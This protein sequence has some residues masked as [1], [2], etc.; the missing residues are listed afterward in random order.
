MPFIKAAI[1]IPN[2]KRYGCLNISVF[3]NYLMNKVPFS[4]L[5]KNLSI[6]AQSHT[7]GNYK[8]HDAVL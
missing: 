1:Y 7:A 6:H 5:K 3:L 4:R 8:E 2:V